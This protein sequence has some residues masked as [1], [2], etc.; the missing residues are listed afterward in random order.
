MSWDSELRKVVEKDFQIGDR[1]T[2]DEIYEYE[3]HFSELYPKNQ[4]VRDGL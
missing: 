4:H 3:D 1:F 2:L